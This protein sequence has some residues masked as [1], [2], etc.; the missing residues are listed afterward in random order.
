MVASRQS[1]QAGQ[2]EC[3]ARRVDC[4]SPLPTLF[5]WQLQWLMMV[6]T[7]YA[8]NKLVCSHPLLA[9]L[10]RHGGGAACVLP[11]LYGSGKAGYN[12]AY[13]RLLITQ[14]H[15]YIAHNTRQHKTACHN[16]YQL[17]YIAV[18]IIYV[19]A[20]WHKC[21]ATLHCCTDLRRTR[22]SSHQLLNPAHTGMQIT[23]TD[24]HALHESSC[25]L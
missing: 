13:S 20:H 17:V 2:G 18:V 10:T 3:N 22:P 9:A 25:R 8:L 11:L 14:A 4:V 1:V 6:H 19:E 16:M 12:L 23:C 24:H 7:Y 21:T 15:T 5:S